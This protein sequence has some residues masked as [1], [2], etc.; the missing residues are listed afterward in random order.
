MCLEVKSDY[1]KS[2][3]WL[4]SLFRVGYIQ[5]HETNLGFWGLQDT[6]KIFG[7]LP[8]GPRA[9]FPGKF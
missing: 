4:K 6:P 2:S 9:C 3:A 5:G 1:Q 7:D 8:G